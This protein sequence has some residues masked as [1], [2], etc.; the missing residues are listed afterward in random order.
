MI[1]VVA[2]VVV[3]VPVAVVVVTCYLCGTIVACSLA[4]LH[5]LKIQF[6]WLCC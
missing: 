5:E 6:D 4:S 3:T 2:V 1:A